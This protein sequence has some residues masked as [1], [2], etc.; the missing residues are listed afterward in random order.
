MTDWSGHAAGTLEKAPRLSTKLLVNV[1][2]IQFEHVVI[3]IEEI[4]SPVGT[5]PYE[6][7][8][9]RL[10]FGDGSFDDFGRGAKGNVVTG[11]RTLNGRAHQRNPDA[12]QPEECFEMTLVVLAL[13]CSGA[14]EVMKQRGGPGR[15]LYY[16]GYVAD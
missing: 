5:R 3:V 2:G 9:H 12:S 7:A 15:V 4:Q 10:K 1:L 11:P 6:L 16:E 14:E 8:P 13:D